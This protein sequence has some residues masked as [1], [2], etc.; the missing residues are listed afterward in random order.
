[1]HATRMMY[2]QSKLPLPVDLDFLYICWS[3]Q[4]GDRCPDIADVYLLGPHFRFSQMRPMTLAVCDNN[5]IFFLI[6]TR[7]SIIYALLY[8]SAT[9]NERIFSGGGL[10]MKKINL[11][12][13]SNSSDFHYIFLTSQAPPCN[14][15]H[16]QLL[17]EE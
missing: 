4:F 2:Q 13:Y 6:S 1:M 14:T 16:I 17:I 15:R 10:W 11:C 9:S 8:I 5:M 3:L 7:K 12:R